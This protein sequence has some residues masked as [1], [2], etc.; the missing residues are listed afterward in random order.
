MIDP[1][2]TTL[3]ATMVFN[4]VNNMNGV[5]KLGYYYNMQAVDMTN[6]LGLFS[7]APAL[8]RKEQNAR[9]FTAWALYAWQGYVPDYQLPP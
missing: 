6:K 4:N 1:K 5:D 9:N 7:P 8:S 3:Q 2:L